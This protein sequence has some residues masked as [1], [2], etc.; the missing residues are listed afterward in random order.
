M[1][2]ATKTLQPDELT[3]FTRFFN[4]VKSTLPKPELLVY[5]YLDADNLKQNI[6]KRGRSYEKNIGIDYLEKIQSGYFEYIR[7]NQD[8]RTLI[9]DTNRVDFVKNDKDYNKVLEIIKG[10]YEAGIHRFTLE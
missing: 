2:F 7:Q 4:I 6:A 10:K 8:I 5:L 1:I 3:L 9:I